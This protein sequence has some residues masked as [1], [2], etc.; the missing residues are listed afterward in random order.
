MIGAWTNHLW[1]STV[2]AFAA[3]L[4][5]VA[6]RK[7][8]A[9]VRYWLWFSASFKFFVPF[10][11]LMSFGSHLAWAPA[12]AKIA[13][14]SV[15]FTMVQITQPF[16]GALPLAP[17]T[18][19]T[20]DW[21]LIA[22]LGVWACGFSGVT[23]IRFRGWLRIRAARRASTPIDIPAS[24]EVRSSPGLLEPGVVGLLR[25]ILLLPA[26]IAERL[27]PPQLEAVLAHEL[28]HVQRRDNLF[29]SIH[30]IAESAFW[31]HPLVWWIGTRLVEERERACDEQVLSLGN[32]PH[33]YAEG[34]LNVCKL[35]VESPLVCVSGVTGSN[36]NKR[37]E[38]I[39][40]NRMVLRL[41]F[42]R[43]VALAVSGIAALAAPIA[44]GVMNAPLIRAQS[45]AAAVPKFE[46]SSIRP[47][48][49]EPGLMLG[50]GYSASAGRLNTGCM[51][52]VDSASLG[53]IQRAYVRFAGGPSW[54]A[55]VP[56][57]GGP[58]WIHSALYDIHAKAEGNPN[59]EVMQG[60]MLQALLEDRFELRTHRETRE[61]P[62]YA[63]TVAQGGSN[64]T[65]FQV[66]TC[67]K[68]PMKVPLPALASGQEYCKVRI[69]MRAVDA[70]GSIE[71]QGST[72]AEFAHMLTLVLD[73]PV[74]DKTRIAGTFDI[75]LEFAAGAAS[76]PTGAS[77]LTAIQQLGLKLEPTKG[78]RE[79]LVIDHAERPT[80]N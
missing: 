1:Q 59:E 30:M 16:P 73:R 4:L 20:H 53:L 63:L 50:A 27:T 45:A 47:C 15:S 39:M 31:F 77:I 51:P 55:I 29:A 46:A 18:S 68:M 65:P 28:C 33:V 80:E 38:A 22:I 13:A 5:T 40:K 32:E 41:S 6:F 49:A 10:S 36:L 24:I 7:N 48:S 43:K 14:P 60:P 76:D 71:A 12:A 3:G 79:F 61:V 56:I 2:F 44:I 62:V 72:L 57:E 75:H 19:G 21:V 52:L 8:R 23:L 70:Q 66:G 42:A 37:I 34:I 35:Y 26:G 17:S 9:P 67:T 64:L 54:P 78:L 69:G 11:L 74:I 58:A 25:P